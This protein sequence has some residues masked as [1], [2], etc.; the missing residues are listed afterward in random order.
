M[1]GIARGQGLLGIWGYHLAPGMFENI[2]IV[3]TLRIEAD[4]HKH[5]SG[6]A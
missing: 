4:D 1:D 6:M 2:S 3:G 5:R